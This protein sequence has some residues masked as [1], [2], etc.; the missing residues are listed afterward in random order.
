[1]RLKCRLYEY[2]RNTVRAHVNDL[3]NLRYMAMS[4]DQLFKDFLKSFLREFMELFYPDAARSLNFDTTHFLDKE[5]Y[6]DFPEGS[7]RQADLV[8]QLETVDG[9]PE[10]L[11]VHLEVQAERERSFDTRMFEYYALLWFRYRLPILPIVVYLSGG[12][13]TSSREEYTVRLLGR[14]LLKYTY[15]CLGFSALNAAEYAAKPNPVA[16]AL[17]ALMNPRRAPDPLKLRALMLLRVA[18]SDLDDARK[19]LLVNLIETYFSLTPEEGLAFGRL[20]E[21]SEFREVRE[22]Q[23]TWA[24]RIMEEG[25]EKGREEGR[26]AGVLE[27]KRE[28]LLRQLTLKFGPLPE[29]VTSRV[30]AMDSAV[31]LDNYLERLLSA[32]SLPE[33]GLHWTD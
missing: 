15:D 20:V 30:K 3:D 14:E 24:D 17:A 10:L 27:G 25:R 11:L 21:L 2:V 18:R 4:H 31:D 26:Q 32:S 16:A 22:M 28:I 1:M 9:D 6:T 19:R 7:V 29:V 12:R 8:A 23:V 33:M 13:Q 5:L